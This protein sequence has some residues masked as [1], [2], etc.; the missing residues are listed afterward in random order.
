MLQL[1]HPYVAGSRMTWGWGVGKQ[2]VARRKAT[3]NAG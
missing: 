3:R 2:E 1:E